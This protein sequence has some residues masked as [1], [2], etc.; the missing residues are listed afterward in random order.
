MFPI[1][2]RGKD[3]RTAIDDSV[4]QCTVL[5]A[6]IGPRWTTIQDASGAR[7]IE[8]PNDFVRLEIASALA[9]G[10]DVIPVL[11]HEARMPNPSE[12]PESLQNLSYRNGVDGH[13]CLRWNSDVE[14]FDPGPLREYVKRG[15]EIPT[16]QIRSVIQPVSTAVSVPVNPLPAATPPPPPPPRRSGVSNGIAILIV[17]LALI[18]GAGG[19][20][21]IHQL[22]KH[23]KRG[24]SPAS[25]TTRLP[26]VTA[27]RT[28]SLG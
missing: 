11:V 15:R 28:S 2:T 3:F 9:K 13:A 26:H 16:L 25:E 7:R 14:L 12:L 17:V 24:E 5:L 21:V 4:A 27:E 8:Q 10:I 20:I 19:Y 1:S 23:H 22:L 6:V 18:A